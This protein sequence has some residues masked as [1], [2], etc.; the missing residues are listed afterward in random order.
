[1]E[2]SSNWIVGWVG[3]SI[4]LLLRRDSTVLSRFSSILVTSVDSSWDMPEF[5]TA[6]RIVLRYPQCSFLGKGLMIPGQLIV[7]AEREFNLFCGFDEVWCFDAPPSKS[8]PDDLSIVAPRDFGKENPPPLLI[9][10]MQ[11]SGC[12]LA[13]G[14]GDGLNYA[15]PDKSL[16][17]LLQATV[18]PS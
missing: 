6:K 9:P 1:M 7:T 13:M 4:G 14:D 3:I 18:K 12:R 10:W 16:A 5:L 8:K 11:E 17:D 2:T 15:T